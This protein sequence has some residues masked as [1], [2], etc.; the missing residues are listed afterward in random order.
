MAKTLFPHQKLEW[1]IKRLKEELESRGT[2]ASSKTDASSPE[3]IAEG[4]PGDADDPKRLELA[5]NLLSRSIFHGGGEQPAGEALHLCRK[6][7]VARSAERGGADARGHGAPRDEPPR[8]CAE[9]PRPGRRSR[10]GATRP[11]P[12]PRGPRARQGRSRAGGAA[13]RVRVSLGAGLVGDEPLPRASARRSRAPAGQP[14]SPDRAEPVP[15]REGAAARAAAGRARGAPEGRRDLVPPHGPLSR[16]GEVL[17]A[18]AGARDLR[19]VRAL[20]PRPGRVQP[21][22]VPQR[23][24]A[25]PPGADQPLGRLEGPRAD[26]NGVVPARRARPSAR[27]LSASAPARAR[28]TSPRGTRS[29]ARSSKRARRPRR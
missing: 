16:G 4:G 19:R 11:A 14:A 24:P 18:A 13:V 27:G 8:G 9:A 7:L 17:H 2:E 10:R 20:L 3:R 5:R 25:L 26:G 23:H 12:V 21:R 22:Q 29:A 6:I 28:E 1:N 15:P